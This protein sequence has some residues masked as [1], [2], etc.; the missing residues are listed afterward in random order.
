MSEMSGR[1]VVVT[2]ATT[3]IGK[4]SARQLLRKG[5][6]VVIVGRDPAKIDATEV[7]LR[8]EIP[9]AKLSHVRCDF[10]SLASVRTA[11]ATLAERHPAIHVLLNNA[12]A[13]HQERK[14]SEDGHE[15]TFQTNH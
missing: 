4:E 5:A 8:A 6:E 11:G 14:L 3:G 10:A 12:G 15:L 2:G 1:V 7:E 9:S 13:L